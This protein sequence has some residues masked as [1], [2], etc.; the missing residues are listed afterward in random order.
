MK[1]EVT[2]EQIEH[3]QQ[4]GF[5]VIPGFLD[6]GELEHWRAV[7]AAAVEMRL[8]MSNLNNQRDPDAFYAQVFTQALRLADIY[9]PMAEL[10]FDADLGRTAATLAGIDGIRIWHDQ[11]LIKPPYGNHTAF[12]MDDPFWSFSSPN[13]ISI[14]VALDEATLANGCLWYL[15]GTHKQVTYAATGIG[16]NL[17]SLF[18]AYPQFRDLEAVAAPCPA[19]SAVFHNGLIAHGAGANMTPHAR[20]AMTCAFMPDGSTFNGTQNVLPD[21]Y[22]NSLKI[23]DLLNNDTINRLTWHKDGSHKSVPAPVFAQ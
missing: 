12:H 5:I 16:E 7:T 13:A 15:P 23:G 18:K 4:N 6:P 21:D 22:F 2:P 11:A 17:G 20:R 1:T 3:Y 10:I 14:W 19:G 8:Q 9:R